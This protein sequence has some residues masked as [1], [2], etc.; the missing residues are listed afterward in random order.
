MSQNK[1]VERGWNFPVDIKGALMEAVRVG[2]EEVAKRRADIRAGRI[3]INRPK[4]NV[5]TFQRTY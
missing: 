1:E 3:R 5:R 4:F 2:K